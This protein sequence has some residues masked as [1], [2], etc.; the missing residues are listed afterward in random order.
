MAIH[1]SDLSRLTRP[2][3]ALPDSGEEDAE[4]SQRRMQHRVNNA[5]AHFWGKVSQLTFWA[6]TATL[7]GSGAVAGALGVSS[8]LITLG[9]GATLGTISLITSSIENRIRVDNSL[10]FEEIQAKNIGRHTGEEVAKAITNVLEGRAME[11][12]AS[13][14]NESEQRTP[15][16]NP[17]PVG[18]A[19]DQQPTTRIE[20]QNASMEA[21]TALPQGVTLH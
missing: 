6:M 18:I 21:R 13:S 4:I 3:P 20:T 12:Q 17:I 16:S 7:I 8:L 19:R 2:E 11:R 5:R 15:A 9:I 1:L 10:N 14:P